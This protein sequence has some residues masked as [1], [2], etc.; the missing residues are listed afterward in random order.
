MA[1]I[2]KLAAKAV[3]G[4]SVLLGLSAGSATA[5]TI[6]TTSVSLPNGSTTVNIVD[7]AQS[8]DSG[9]NNIITGTIGLQTTASGALN[10]YCVDLFDYINVGSNAYT[11]NNNQLAAGQ[12]FR[13]GTATGTW[14]TGQ[15]NMITALLTNGAMQTQNTINTAA[16]QIAIWEVEYDNKQ[17]N[18]TYSLSIHD[19]FYFTATGDSNSAATLSMAQTY[20]NNITSGTWVTD[21]NH[22]AM[23]LTSNPTGTQ[24]LVYL[25]TVVGGSPV[26][27]PSTIAVFGLGLIGLWAVRRRLTA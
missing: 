19:G 5:G 27:E 18:G 20:L 10:T 14:T 16:L 25:Q 13:N 3:F 4:V 6:T 21:A 11:F 17:T 9:G 12:T 7:T 26:P 2:N 22:V 8:V 23:Y 15:V 1:A 24:N